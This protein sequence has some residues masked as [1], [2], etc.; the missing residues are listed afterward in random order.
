MK[1]LVELTVAD[2][3]ATA[4]WR[5][6]GGTGDQAIVVPADR[7]SLS[8]SD[9]EVFLARTEFTLPDGS[10]HPGFCFPV[11][12][13]GVDYLQ[14]VIVTEA[15]QVRFWFE[16][17]VSPAAL[18]GQ[19]A[20]LG[21]G[22]EEIFPVG[23]R[24]LVPVD[25]RTV[26]GVISQVE[27]SPDVAA[28]P[29]PPGA[30]GSDAGEDE[31]DSPKGTSTGMRRANGSFLLARPVRARQSPKAPEP[32]EKRRGPRHPVEMTVDF[33]HDSSQGTGVISN[34]SRGGMF[35]RSP[36]VP[37][38]GPQ[39]R[40][41]VHLPDGRTL[42]LKGKVVRSAAAEPSPNM[43]GSGFGVRLAADSPDYA[44]FLSQLQNKPHKN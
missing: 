42:L 5:Y 38:T 43:P 37:N 12:D 29:G 14:P 28:S 8:I 30:P 44:K 27:H 13:T 1:R 33:S 32:G 34:M 22:V 31:A 11:D 6:E 41:T 9:D 25:D 15:G 40:L 18:A 21:R 36:R 7:S 2:L 26:A 23:F 20:Y 3:A 24:C 4:V 17:P 16:G 19:W 35:V 10:R 39:L